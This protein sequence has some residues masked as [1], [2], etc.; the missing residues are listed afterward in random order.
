MRNNAQRS[1]KRWKR[2]N[3]SAKAQTWHCHNCGNRHPY[4]YHCTKEKPAA[5]P[6][7]AFYRLPHL[8]DFL[9]RGPV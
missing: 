4:G 3:R 7:D 9:Q 1:R 2:E 8:P 6:R 5:L